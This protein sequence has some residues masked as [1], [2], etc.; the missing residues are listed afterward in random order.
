MKLWEI[1]RFEVGYQLRRPWTWV[2]FATLFALSLKIATD[3]YTE[4]AR[5]G[6]YSFNGPYVIASIT[7]LGSM[8]ALLVIA[9]FAGDA[10]ARDAQTRM[11]PLVYTLPVGKAAYLR[12]RFLAAFALSAMIL[13]AV[14]LAALLSMFKPG[15]APDLLGPFRPGAYLEAYVVIALCNAFVAAALFF[16]VATLS[17]RASAGYLGAALLFF[18][19][20]IV[21]LLVAGEL[22][23]WELAKIID[24]LGLTVIS[25]IERTTTP[26]QKNTI[27]IGLYLP[28]LINR[29]VW[30]AIALGVFALTHFRFRFAHPGTRVRRN[31]TPGARSESR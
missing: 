26:L 9:S 1:F 13:A 8:M 16:S 21:R 6:G 12:G 27:S 25:E 17:R 15:L 23:N 4:N 30:L 10:G 31:V 24:P 2:Y 22:G 7:V 14:P 29:A 28:L 3:A 18:T 19:A 11:H 5:D 20:F